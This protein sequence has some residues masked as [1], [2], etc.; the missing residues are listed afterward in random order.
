[1]AYEA[2]NN[3]GSSGARLIV[4]LN[5]N[6]MSI[7]PP[8]GAMSNYLSRL[9]SSRS[10]LNLRDFAG[11]V[12]R[13]LPHPIEAH[14]QAGRRVR[15]RHPD[16]RHAVRGARLL[17]RGAGRRPQHGPPAA[18]PAQTCARRTSRVRVAAA[19][20]HQKGRGYAPAEASGDKFHAVSKFNVI[21]GEQTKAPPGA[22]DLYLGVRPGPAGRRR[23]RSE[24]SWRSP[25]RCRPGPGSTSSPSATPIASS[26]SALPS[27][28][29]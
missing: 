26:M 22:A 8:V 6:E 2:M 27:S 13:R 4:V 12:A 28:M 15:P 17:L 1:M 24:G 20:D 5:D 29:R 19:R 23:R 18:D 16:R 9:M 7:A 21:T 10:F 14:R 3:A 25:R 11:R